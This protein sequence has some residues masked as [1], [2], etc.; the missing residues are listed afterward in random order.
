MA[1]REFTRAVEILRVDESRREVYGVVGS[2]L[3]KFA[4]GEIVPVDVYLRAK[5]E[6]RV[7]Y[8]GGAF[9]ADDL[10]EMAHR[11]LAQAGAAAF[12][13]QHDNK[14][15]VAVCI[16]SFVATD[17]M[18]PWA[19]GS[20]VV[21]MKVLDDDVWEKIIS[22]KYKGFSVRMLAADED[23]EIVLDDEKKTRIKIKYFHDPTPILVS[24]VDRPATGIQFE[25]VRFV[26]DP[27]AKLPD[28]EGPAATSQDTRPSEA[29]ADDP[30]PSSE[31]TAMAKPKTLIDRIV[32]RLSGNADSEAAELLQELQGKRVI[33]RAAL[34]DF[35]SAWAK[36]RATTELYQ[37]F[38]LLYAFIYWYAAVPA[39]G[40]CPRCGWGQWNEDGVCECCGWQDDGTVGDIAAA[41]ATAAAYID[42]FKAVIV[43]ALGKTVVERAE[44][45]EPQVVLAAP[46][47][48]MAERVRFVTQQVVDRAGKKL[49]ATSRQAVEEALEGATAACK[50]LEALLGTVSEAT[51]EETEETQRSEGA[52]DPQ[53]ES[54]RSEVEA[55]KA[56]IET[57]RAEA[58]KSV[59]PAAEPEPEA[60]PAVTE[61]DPETEQLRSEVQT[62][63]AAVSRLQAMRPAPQAAAEVPVE[64]AENN[65]PIDPR[66]DPYKVFERS[67]FLSAAFV[68]G[69]VKG[70]IGGRSAEDDE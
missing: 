2:P 66:K 19:P 7:H 1:A 61:P 3:Q 54:L 6:G 18:A 62:L 35:A 25:I 69:G 58:E 21:G 17:S 46:G 55:M 65:E 24:I 70:N 29:A 28:V 26:S 8:D 51:E 68:V 64:R 47:V 60:A 56:Q 53:I 50:A 43:E 22:K 23:V 10:S 44:G 16:E 37:A 59:E 39:A 9:L 63:Q 67:G 34:P 20:W 48:A 33:D 52:P 38:E 32:A 13:Q 11:F 41:Q 36:G 14:S 40:G 45:Q 30:T 4:P 5:A 27:G 49:S 42:Q 15:G 31:E 12:D 57:L